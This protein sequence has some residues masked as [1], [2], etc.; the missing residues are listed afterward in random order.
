GPGT[1]DNLNRR[2]LY[3]LSYPPC[4]FGRQSAS[5]PKLRSA[6]TL[7]GVAR[8]RLNISSFGSAIA[9]AQLPP[10]VH[11]GND[12][13][14]QGRESCFGGATLLSARSFASGQALGASSLLRR[15]CVIRV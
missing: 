5:T 7:G 11:Q 2:R 8:K 6:A 3:A 9:V 1:A 4:F 13:A 14:T 10:R 15:S 12:G